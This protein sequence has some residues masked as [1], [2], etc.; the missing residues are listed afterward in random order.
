MEI[1]SLDHFL[2]NFI[3]KMKERN[4]DGLEGKIGS[5]DQLFLIQEK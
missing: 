4:S 3:I 1:G 2:K 5:R